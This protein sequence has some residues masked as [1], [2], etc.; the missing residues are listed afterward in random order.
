M[1]VRANRNIISL[2]KVEA[3]AI[4][5]WDNFFLMK[6]QRPVILDD[7]RYDCID[8]SDGALFSLGEN[9]DVIP[10]NGEFVYNES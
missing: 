6:L 5:K 8:I 2:C 1:K 4:V 3:G 9:S 10:L 7:C